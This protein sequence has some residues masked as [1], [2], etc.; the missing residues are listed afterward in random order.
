MA[1][2]LDLPRELY[3]IICS[4]LTPPELARLGGVSKDHYLAVQQALY[5]HIAIDS[6]SRL[7]KLVE[8][9]AKVPVVSR[10][11]AQQRLRWF[12]LSDAQLRE[13]DI[14]TLHL[15]LD[16][17]KDGHK[18]IGAVVINCIGAISRKCYSV[19]IQLSLHGAWPGWQQQLARFGMPNVGAA[20]ILVASDNKDDPS[21]TVTQTW[22]LLFS[23]SCFSDLK[24]V[25]VNTSVDQPSHLP[26]DLLRSVGRAFPVPASLD[27]GYNPKPSNNTAPFFG[28]RKMEEIVLEHSQH[29]TV[30]TMTSL[31]GSDII[32]EHLTKLE[33]VD[34]PS[35]HPV[36]HLSAICT[37]LQRALQLVKHLKLHLCKLPYHGQGLDSQYGARIDE[38]PEEHP[39]IIIREL[40]DKIP[41]L[42]LALPYVCSNIFPAASTRT[43]TSRYDEA[44]MTYPD[45]PFEPYNTLPERVVAAGYK[46]RRLICWHD[47]CRHTHSWDDVLEAA[48]NMGENLSWDLLSRH[49]ETGSW[50]VSGYLAMETKGKE[51]LQRPFVTR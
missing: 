19:K 17:V 37:L 8:T 27:W 42:D 33:V 13:R 28:L 49:D 30:D 3:L 2:M 43:K 34:C 10:I 5:N 41:Y 12:K 32:P 4:D 20:T 14:K 18:I 38:H 24:R 48:E 47:I 6:Y 1:T 46:Y 29:L 40:S 50:R 16:R 39:C 11:S 51:I 9:L 44:E 23:G 26:K 7:V 21:G 31:F 45:I 35:L 22:D 36:R 15:I 25:Y